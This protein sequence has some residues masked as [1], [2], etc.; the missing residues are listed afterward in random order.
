MSDFSQRVLVILFSFLIKHLSHLQ[1]APEIESKLNGVYVKWCWATG[2][3]ELPSTAFTQF[4]FFFRHRTAKL[5]YPPCQVVICMCN[6]VWVTF[7][8]GQEA[9]PDP[10]AVHMCYSWCHLRRS[11]FVTLKWWQAGSFSR[12]VHLEL[13]TGRWACAGRA[14]RSVSRLTG[15]SF[16]FYLWD[17]HAGPVALKSPSQLP[18]PYGTAV[19]C[20]LSTGWR[21]EWRA[22]IKRVPLPRA[23]ACPLRLYL[24]TPDWDGFRSCA[25]C[26]T[27]S[28]AAAGWDVMKD[29][30]PGPRAAASASR[31]PCN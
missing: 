19:I 24:W 14:K 8:Q 27:A 22:C 25:G 23:G 7:T 9:G 6:T 10:P 26:D 18:R 13:L 11:P 12:R 28:A 31:D 17:A 4:F 29:G 21:R 20:I 15:Q 2:N 5:L 30:A 3:W 16:M 1:I